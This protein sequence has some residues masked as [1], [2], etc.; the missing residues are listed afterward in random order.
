MA[1]PKMKPSAS[2]RTQHI[3]VINVDGNVDE[4]LAA[5][6]ADA[7]ALAATVVTAASH[8]G[9]VVVPVGAM[10]SGDHTV[11]GHIVL[12]LGKARRTAVSIEVRTQHLA[13]SMGI[14]K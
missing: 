9:T 13:A 3:V 5:N 11:V 4:V 8:L 10:S 12:D 14:K 7:A 2:D 6:A 1:S